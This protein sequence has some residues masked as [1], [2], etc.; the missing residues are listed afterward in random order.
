MSSIIAIPTQGNRYQLNRASDVSLPPNADDDSL[1]N[2]AEPESN[3]IEPRIEPSGTIKPALVTRT[4]AM[5]GSGEGGEAD[6]APEDELEAEFGEKVA[7][8]GNDTK[9][10]TL[11]PQSAIGRFEFEFKSK[12]AD[13]LTVNENKTPAAAPAGFEHIEPSSFQVALGVS[14]GVGLTLAKID[15][16]FDIGNAALAGKDLSQSRVGRL[17]TD[18]S[19]FVIDETL[20]SLKFD[21][22]EG[23]ISLTLNDG[24]VAEGEWGIFL[25]VAIARREQPLHSRGNTQARNG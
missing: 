14:R 20:G 16:I 8:E 3:K 15:Y 18:T 21:V 17:N 22:E 5:V 13:E 11:F 2:M 23:E 7:L 1:A 6:E 12:T 24:V 19:A 9:I 25:P 10:D 4:A